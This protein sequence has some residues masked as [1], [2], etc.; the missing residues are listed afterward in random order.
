LPIGVAA[1]SCAW[2]IGH[3]PAPDKALANPF[4]RR[5]YLPL[6][7]E[8]AT[9][10]GKAKVPLVAVMCGK[11]HL[12]EILVAMTRHL[13]Y[14]WEVTY[15][16]PGGQVSQPAAKIFSVSKAVLLFGEVMISDR[17]NETQIMF[18][19]RTHRIGSPRRL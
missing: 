1:F 3:A 17:S 2:Q 12:P 19:E 5:E 7:E 11:S 9:A 4:L 10:C 15:L 18:P 8:L 6:Y 14:R 13:K 16:T